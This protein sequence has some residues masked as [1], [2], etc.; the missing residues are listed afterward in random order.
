MRLTA[1]FLFC[2][3]KCDKSLKTPKL[4]ENDSSFHLTNKLRKGI[5]VYVTESNYRFNNFMT[6]K[7]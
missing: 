4:L 5:I 1:I 2:S 6:W 7:L 3:K